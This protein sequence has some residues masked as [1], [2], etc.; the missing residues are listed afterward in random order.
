LKTNTSFW[1][2]RR[3]VIRSHKGGRWQIGKGVTSHGYSMLDELV[4]H[5]SFFQVLILHV[6]GRMPE[7]RL[8]EWME[9]I[10]ISL[11]WPDPRM[12]P[13]QIGSLGGSVRSSP[14][15][16]ICL[17]TLASDSRI[18][19]PG[20]LENACR[21]IIK[22]MEWV[23]QDRTIEDYLN[24]QP[25]RPGGHIIAPGYI[26]PFAKGDERV[27]VMEC[28]AEKLGFETGAHLQLGHEIQEVLFTRCG[29]SMNLA[30]YISA[31][32]LDQ[33]FSTEE[34]YRVCSL[35]VSGGVHACYSE[36]ADRE[37]ESFLPMRCD[38]IEYCGVPER[39]ITGGLSESKR[40]E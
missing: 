10:F 2:R 22:A 13:N 28:L 30:G 11:S 4:G 6:I 17:G 7:R 23:T 31:F 21:F 24:A 1:D 29:E 36:A 20:T 32:L 12:W 9:A 37:P 38:D 39:R 18:Y 26:R 3:G 34:V 5:A 19:G 8:A 40:I 35:V 15:A 25:R 14:L 33:A 16:A 27:A